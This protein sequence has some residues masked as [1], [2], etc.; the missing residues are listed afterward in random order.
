MDELLLHHGRTDRCTADLP[1]LHIDACWKQR[2]T[3]GAPDTVI[4]V[5]EAATLL[6]GNKPGAGGKVLID[7]RVTGK[8]EHSF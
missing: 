4:G 2:S 1:G 3:S 6:C 7:V 8:P 5:A